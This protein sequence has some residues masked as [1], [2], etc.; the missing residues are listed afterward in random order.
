MKNLSNEEIS[1]EEMARMIAEGRTEDKEGRRLVQKGDTVA[2]LERTLTE[3]ISWGQLVMG[4]IRSVQI[5]ALFGDVAFARTVGMLVAMIPFQDR[6][7]QFQEDVKKATVTKVTHTGQWVDRKEFIKIIEDF[8]YV[9]LFQAC[10]NLF[11]RR[12]I[13]WQDSQQEVFF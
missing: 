10:I 3:S 1:P 9:A 8:D 5:S 2:T 7:E 13:L 6:D 11:R 12:G 4:Q